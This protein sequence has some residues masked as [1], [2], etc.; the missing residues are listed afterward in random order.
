MYLYRAVSFLTWW[1]QL[2]RRERQELL[3]TPDD[4]YSLMNGQSGWVCF[5]ADVLCTTRSLATPT[6]PSSSSS[7]SSPSDPSSSSS[8][9]KS[10]AASTPSVVSFMNDGY[11]GF[12][13]FEV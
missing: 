2:A 8:S 10:A 1:L 4:P 6:V 3:A 13:G 7:S 12:P 9:N 5:A 11:M